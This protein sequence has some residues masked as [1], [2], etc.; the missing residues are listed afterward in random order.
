MM[1]AVYGK[2]V[3]LLIDEYD[4]PLAKAQSNGYYRQMLELIRGL[5][6]TSLKTNEYLKFAVVTGCLRIPKDTEGVAG[7]SIF[8]G[9]NNFASY[10]VLDEEFAQYY[11]FTHAD[12]EKMLEEFGL[13]EKTDVFRN[14]YDGYVFGNTEVYCPWDVVNYVSALLKRKTARPKNY[15]INTSGTDAIKAFFKRQWWTI[16]IVP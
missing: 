5:M 13:S 8:T 9:V 12:V 15:W 1:N 16:L 14:W 6:S 3:I 4:V 7:Q 10:S 2:Q 11:G